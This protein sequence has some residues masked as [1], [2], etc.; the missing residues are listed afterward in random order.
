MKTTWL[1]VEP[2]DTL[3]VRD[4]RA[5][6]AGQ[7]GRGEAVAPP[8]STLGG[9]V[10]HALGGKVKHR[11]VG[12]VVDVA[13]RQ[14]FPA[15]A[16]LVRNDNG[17]TAR[18]DVIERPA[19]VVSDLDAKHRFSHVLDGEGSPERSWITAE[20]LQAWLS[21]E[22]APGSVLDF[23]D[24]DDYLCSE[25]WTQESR[26]GLAREWFGEHRDTAAEGMLYLANHLRVEDGTRFLVGCQDDKALTVRNDLA[27]IGGR[28]RLAHVREHGG[29]PLPAAAERFPDGR[30]TAYLATP[31]LLNDVFW[32]P[33]EARLCAVAL[34]G[35][36]PIASASR[37]GKFGDT[38]LLRWAVPAGTV[39]YLQFDSEADAR[40]WSG[41]WHGTLLP[42]GAQGESG[43]NGESRIATAGFGT[44]LTG[45]W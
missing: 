11:I 13:G 12:P 43:S 26:L 34:T 19:G 27:P 7:T 31:A 29:N 21:G 6:D 22:F 33:P 3:M 32:H 14:R 1:A 40:R 17:E 18:L 25:P 44:C 45:S 16:D 28:G 9:V 41:Q 42:P 2:L 39:Y 5:F 38:R 36:A 15:P 30:L 20:G 8:P 37:R 10:G 24:Q 35:P 23:D 4:G